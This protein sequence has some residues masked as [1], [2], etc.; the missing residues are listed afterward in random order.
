MDF[1]AERGV[2]NDQ[3]NFQ[4]DDLQQHEK[5]DDYEQK[6]LKESAEAWSGLS[7]NLKKYDEDRIKRVN[8]DMD[9]L[10]VFAGLFSAVV[11]AFCVEIYKSLQQDSSETSVILLSQISRQLASFNVN[12]LT[13]NSSAPAA[14]PSL[15][16]PTPPSKTSVKINIFWFLSLVFSLT[17]ASL[18]MLVKQWL[19][20]YLAHDGLSS[21]PHIR[22]R[23]FRNEGMEKFR[24]FE[25]AAVLPML[26]QI[27]LGL[28]LIGLANFLIDLDLTVGWS[29]TPFI[30]FWASLFVMTLFAPAVFAHCPYHTPLLKGLLHTIRHSLYKPIAYIY[31]FV[32][33]SYGRRSPSETP[34]NR[35]KSSAIEAT[36]KYHRIISEC[37]WLQMVPCV[38]LLW[39]KWLLHSAPCHFFHSMK[40]QWRF[41]FRYRNEHPF[42]DERMVREDTSMDFTHLTTN[43]VKLMDNEYI[44]FCFGAARGMEYKDVN[45][46]YWLTVKHNTGYS[47]DEEHYHD[48]FLDCLLRRKDKVIQYTDKEYPNIVHVLGQLCYLSIKGEYNRQ[49]DV[50]ALCHAFLCNGR[51]PA[52]LVLS[53][54]VDPFTQFS[55][56]K[57]F[58]TQIEVSSDSAIKHFI[59]AVSEIT[60]YLV[61]DHK[62]E[63]GTQSKPDLP[64]NSLHGGAL[65]GI[66]VVPSERLPRLCLL[67]YTVLN[68][69]DE[70]LIKCHSDDLLDMQ[71]SLVEAVDLLQPPRWVPISE[72]E[73]LQKTLNFWRNK[74]PSPAHQEATGKLLDSLLVNI[75]MRCGREGKQAGDI[76]NS[77]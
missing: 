58:F 41:Y 40:L 24:V 62:Y 47:F 54:C 7:S 52:L 9:T 51:Y 23:H 45:T 2:A 59:E 49:N 21:R 48:A 75:R 44:K 35:L 66:F 29:I 10:L 28:F 22:V 50:I 16:T 1:R 25:I 14:E 76:S 17:T 32:N 63:F 8:D 31:L 57:N 77:D 72:E 4:P 11:T 13:L 26:L 5:R 60:L 68:G 38:F 37:N 42:L 12:G 61:S 67:T 3:S 56:L 46:L 71:K 20:E 53:I 64:V 30:I 36:D 34:W 6:G 43:S 19:R 74:A 39:G 18:G 33:Q 27:A 70:S 15:F 55:D 65:A 73:A 69:V